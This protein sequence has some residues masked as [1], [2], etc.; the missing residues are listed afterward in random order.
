MPILP[1]YLNQIFYDLDNFKKSK[2]EEDPNQK[3]ILTEK[4]YKK[5]RLEELIDIHILGDRKLVRRFLED[6][7]LRILIKGDYQNAAGAGP[8]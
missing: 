1:F 8:S 7:I 3:N 6:L 4:L 2:K 5:T